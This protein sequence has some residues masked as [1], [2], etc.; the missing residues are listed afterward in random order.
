[1]IKARLQPITRSEQRAAPRRLVNLG[2]HLRSAAAAG[3]DVR[4][5]DLSQQGCRVTVPG[6]FEEGDQ[7]WLKLPGLETIGC[8]I[9][10][11][12]DGDVG[13]SFHRRLHEAEVASAGTPESI[14]VQRRERFGQKKR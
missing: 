12:E 11:A 1:M 4:V 2:T 10:W 6:T 8:T 13:I 3:S 7:A 9:I 5:Q 14:L